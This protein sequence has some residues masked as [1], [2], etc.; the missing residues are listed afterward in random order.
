M[1]YDT[2]NRSNDTTKSQKELKSCFNAHFQYSQ[3]KIPDNKGV[4]SWNKMW[5][6]KGLAIVKCEGTTS[7]H[8]VYIYVT[9]RLGSEVLFLLF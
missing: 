9:T 4:Y 7:L 6:L 2:R 3:S 1:I 8:V 5:S